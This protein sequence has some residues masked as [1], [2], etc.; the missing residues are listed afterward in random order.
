MIAMLHHQLRSGHKPVQD[1][2]G[3]R[4]KNRRSVK[5]KRREKF[6]RNPGERRHRRVCLNA[7]KNTARTLCPTFRYESVKK[8]KAAAKGHE[9]RPE[10][11]VPS[12]GNQGS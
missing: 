12:L 4:G 1:L 2:T 5:G 8:E 3:E 9:S 7:T 6:T 11:G 10:E